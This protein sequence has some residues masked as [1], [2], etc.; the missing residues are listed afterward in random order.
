VSNREMPAPID[1]VLVKLAARCNLACSYCYFFFGEDQTWRKQPKAIS[2]STV[3]A[4]ASNLADL[5]QRQAKNFAVVLHGGEPLL[6]GAKRLG[7]I[8]QTL[9]GALKRDTP[10]SLQTNGALINVEILDLC[11]EY[12]VSISVSIDGPQSI[13]DKNRLTAAGRSLFEKT[14]SGIASLRNH[15]DSNFLFAGTLTVVDPASDPGEIYSFLKGIGSPSTD[16]LFKDGNHDRLPQG[17]KDF[18]STEY[19]TWL[20][21]L[22]DLY[23]RDPAPIPIRILDDTAKLI[24]GSKGRKEGLGDDAYGIVIIDTDG[25]IAKN[26]TL[27]SSYDGADR[28]ETRWNVNDNPIADILAHPE[29]LDYVTSQRPTAP[30]CQKCAFRSVCGGGMPLYRYSGQRG[31]DNPSIYCEDHKL[32]IRKITSAILALSPFDE[33][34]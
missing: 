3:A 23:V 31:Y 1:T 24:L 14:V 32:V 4:L 30:E 10:I 2:D 19:G 7:G 12:E 11:S 9:R 25:S 13:N 21:R 15:P 16:F 34:H 29:Y 20:T 5:R 27:K 28:F 8:F 17:K 26:D 6:L 33:I 18:R 22:W